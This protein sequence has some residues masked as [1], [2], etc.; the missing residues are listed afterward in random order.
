MQYDPKLNLMI[1]VYGSM[2][3]PGPS[4]TIWAW[5]ARKDD[6]NKLLD[7]I[8]ATGATVGITDGAVVRGMF[9]LSNDPTVGLW[10]IEGTI[11]DPKSTPETPLPDLI[12]NETAQLADR[13]THPVPP[14]DDLTKF[15][16]HQPLTL[17]FTNVYGYA[18]YAW[19]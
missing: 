13:E 12:I 3:A 8:R 9:V 16:Q 2:F 18:Q 19:R 6:L 11:P 17:T 1:S 15:G 5:L 14:Q 7:Q 10:N 4:H